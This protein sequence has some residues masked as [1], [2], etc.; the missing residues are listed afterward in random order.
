MKP[1]LIIQSN[2]NQVL[3]SIIACISKIECSE[4][5]QN[6]IGQSQSAQNEIVKRFQ[7]LVLSNLKITLNNIDWKIEHRPNTTVRDSIDIFGEGDE[8]VVVIELDKTRADQVAKKFVSRIALLHTR[9]IYFLSLCYPGTE[10]MNHLECVK[11]I[12]YCS[13]L[14]VRIK[15]I[16]YAGFIIN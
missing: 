15:N 13:V 1:N 14:A 16:H 12:K 4:F 6:H 3:K 2:D 8:Y 5:F 9:K 7:E 10:N 11:Y